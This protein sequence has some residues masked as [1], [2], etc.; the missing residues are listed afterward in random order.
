M[1]I[2]NLFADVTYEGGASVNGPFL[3]TLGAGAPPPS[4]TPRAGGVLRYNL[5]AGSAYVAARGGGD[6]AVTLLGCAGYLP[7]LPPPGLRRGRGGG[8]V[9]DPFGGLGGYPAPRPRH[10]ARRA[11]GGGR[12][13]D[14]RGA[15]RP[16]D[17]QADRGGDALLLDR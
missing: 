6:W 12:R 2:V 10:G 14:P 17:P 15:R 1:G 3:G 16:G 9:A 13:A 11:V 7:P 5:R 8:F 4:I